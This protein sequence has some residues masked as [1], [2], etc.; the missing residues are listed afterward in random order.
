MKKIILSLLICCSAFSINYPA[1]AQETE[2]ELNTFLYLDT[3]DSFLD[4][5][6]SITNECSDPDK[7][8]NEE[9]MDKLFKTISKTHITKIDRDVWSSFL[10]Y[11]YSSQNQLGPDKHKKIA[12][13]AKQ[14]KTVLKEIKTETFKNKE[15]DI[16]T[17][18]LL[19][20]NMFYLQTM[21]EDY[22]M[23]ANG[24]FPSDLKDLYKDAAS[25]DKNYWKDIV[26]PFT[27]KSGIGEAL[28]DF[29][30]YKKD[31]QFKGCILYEAIGEPVKKYNIYACDETGD[32][33][34]DN[35]KPLTLNG[36]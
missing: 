7:K 2:N 13:M 36:N 29:K 5:F 17:K 4:I 26:N 8:C 12:D 33:L 30:I 23:E 3:M 25:P 9:Y 16:I 15:K 28:A 24:V 21:L 22:S 11:Y 31:L 6:T 18:A 34:K 10:K 19:K 20:T 35:D 1:T 14:F 32:L 27:D